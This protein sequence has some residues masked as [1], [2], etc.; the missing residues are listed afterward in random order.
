MTWDRCKPFR[1]FIRA[2]VSANL[3]PLQVLLN[4]PRHTEYNFWDLRL[5]KAH[6]FAEDFT[7][8]GIPVWWDESQYVNFDVKRKT[9]RSAQ[10]VERAKEQ[11]SKSKSPSHGRYY[12]PVPRAQGGKPLP[13]WREFLEEQARLEGRKFS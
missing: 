3:P 8:E 10:A 6:F 5:M 12:V 4:D 13:T 9:S 2:A 11:D 1:S 7:R